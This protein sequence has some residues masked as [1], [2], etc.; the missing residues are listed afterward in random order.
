MHVSQS[1][2][3]QYSASPGTRAR[4]AR[5][6]SKFGYCSRAQAYELV[7][8][9]RV[10]VN[11]SV[12]RDPERSVNLERDRIQV[13]GQRVQSSAKIYLMLNKPRGLVTTTSDEQ[14]RETV[15]ECLQELPRLVPVGRLDKASEGLLLF[16]N[17]TDWAARITAPETHLDKTYHVQINCLADDELIRKLVA[18]VTTAE[19]DFLAAKQ[20]RVLREGVKNCWLEIVLDEGKN[21]H[22]RR[23]LESLGIEVLRLMRVSIGAL[24]L[25]ALAKGKFRML[26]P[27]ETAAM[28]RHGTLQANSK[29]P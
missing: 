16:T 25:G 4:L 17:D 11:G 19:G 18:G 6:L 9:G 29:H 24:E 7:L 10:Q 20:A 21:R 8:K 14:G 26:T 13:D 1:K 12:Q 3:K 27:E 22:I 23:L 2:R 15:Y 5:A 28:S